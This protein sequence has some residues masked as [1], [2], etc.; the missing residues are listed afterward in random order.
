MYTGQEEFEPRLQGKPEV[1][2]TSEKRLELDNP[3]TIDEIKMQLNQWPGENHQDYLVFQW[4][5]M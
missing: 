2:L 5:C 3:I 1:T 4:I